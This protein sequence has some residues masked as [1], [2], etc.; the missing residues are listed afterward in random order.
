MF[1][2]FTMAATSG[3]RPAAR[4]GGGAVSGATAQG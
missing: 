3:E 4:P 2:L 1:N